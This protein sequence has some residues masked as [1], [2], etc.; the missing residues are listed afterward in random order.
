[1]CAAVICFV[2]SGQIGEQFAQF[3]A[4]LRNIGAEVV[5]QHGCRFRVDRTSFTADEIAEPTGDLVIAR[6][7]RF[8]N[9]S[10]SL[11]LLVELTTFIES[12]FFMTQ[13]GDRSRGGADVYS[14][15]WSIRRNVCASRTITT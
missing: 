15:N 5:G 10:F 2:P 3:V 1:M 12:F 4:D 9:R 7:D 13:H 14:D 11:D 8:E 6:S